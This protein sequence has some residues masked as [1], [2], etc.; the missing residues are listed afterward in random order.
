MQFNYVDVDVCCF[1]LL[2]DNYVDVDVCCFILLHVNYV[3]VDVCCFILLH[4]NY[5]DVQH[6][7]HL[8][9]VG[10]L[11]RVLFLYRN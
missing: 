5:V 3:D 10:G 4:V 11:V 7:I 1:I 9:K 2:H 8:E 6:D